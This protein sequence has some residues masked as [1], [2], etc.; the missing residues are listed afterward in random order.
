MAA[1]PSESRRMLPSG[2]KLQSAE[3]APGLQWYPGPNW[4]PS[5]DSAQTGCRIQERGALMSIHRMRIS[6]VGLLARG[7]EA[8]A[9]SGSRPVAR[10]GWPVLVEAVKKCVVSR[11]GRD[12]V[13]AKASG[14]ALFATFY[15][16][17]ARR[18]APER[19]GWVPSLFVILCLC[20]SGVTVTV[21]GVDLAG[22]AA[23]A[24]P[25][26][27]PRMRRNLPCICAMLLSS[28]EQ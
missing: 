27:E 2:R 16:A 25:Q 15:A 14:S 11:S 20:S 8:Q 21:F 4:Q 24:G 17:P 18:G 7:V 1:G 22:V 3:S 23:P 12:P 6:V 10:P 19:R 13:G 9:A 26:E 28:Q 5:A